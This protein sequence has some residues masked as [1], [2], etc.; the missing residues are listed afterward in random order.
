MGFV[1]GSGCTLDKNYFGEK[2]KMSDLKPYYKQKK[3]KLGIS[4][5]WWN[6]PYCPHCKR[7]LGLIAEEQK[8]DR[9][10]MCNKPLEW[11]AED[12]K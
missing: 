4:F 1:L 8:V 3:R 5:G 6:I 7:Q 2:M 11:G 10:P 12:V 9:C